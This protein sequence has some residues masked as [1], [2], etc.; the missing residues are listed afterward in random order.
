MLRLPVL[1]VFLGFLLLIGNI[2]GVVDVK[3]HA[4]HIVRQL[5]KGGRS[6]VIRQ[7]RSMLCEK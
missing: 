1:R 7:V 6:K 4:E 2:I 3:A 5:K